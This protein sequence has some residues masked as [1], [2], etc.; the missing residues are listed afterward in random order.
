[1]VAWQSVTSCAMNLSECVKI[2]DFNIKARSD[3]RQNYACLGPQSA[4][5]ALEDINCFR[6]PNFRR[7]V[8]NS[9]ILRL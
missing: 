4:G 8:P 1:M 6:T 5:E 9:P 7:Y 2:R 3:S